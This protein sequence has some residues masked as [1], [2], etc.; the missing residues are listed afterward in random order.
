MKKI[1]SLIL[2]AIILSTC[3][4]AFASCGAT[5]TTINIKT[6]GTGGTY[7]A[8]TNAAAPMLATKTGY[9]CTVLPSGGSVDSLKSIGIGDCNMAI[10]QN[11]TMINAYNN[12][13]PD[14]FPAAITNFS[15]LGE[16]YSEVIQIVVKGDL[17]DS[18]KTLA[19]LKGMRVSVGDAG[20][21]VELNAKHF[22][23]AYG[24]T[25]DDIKKQNLSFKD[26]GDAL[27]N[28]QLDAYFVTAGVPNTSIVDVK[29]QKDVRLLSITGAEADKL[30]ADYP[31]YTPYTI[32]KDVYGTADDAVTL[33]VS[34]TLIVR[35]E[36]SEDEVYDICCALFDNLDEFGAAHA[37]G[38][39]VTVEG[40]VKGIPVAQHAGAVK[41]FTEKGVL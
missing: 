7:Y 14:N 36:L 15:V 13:D 23:S 24:L 1:L 19:D 9:T 38:K 20:S 29:V 37:K 8:F 11:D 18:V 31:F 25:F 26:S 21:G 40:A 4:L 2:A 39:E 28:G 33:A 17:K 34:A 6:G 12:L 5:G 16:V 30:M 3:V 10:V 27:K 32:G 41:Y 22:L 35:E